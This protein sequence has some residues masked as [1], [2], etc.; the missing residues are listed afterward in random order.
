MTASAAKPRPR[1]RAT[2]TATSPVDSS[3]SGSGGDDL[4]AVPETD[5]ASRRIFR[6]VKLPE[7]PIFALES[8]SDPNDVVEFTGIVALPGL[9]ALRLVTD[10]IDMTTV[11]T[12]FKQ[13][14]GEEGFKKFEEFANVPE[15]GITLDVLVDLS[16]Y[17]M[18][19]YT[20][21][22]TMRSA[23]S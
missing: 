10:G 2:P 16:K 6:G 4:A 23:G 20:G 5:D 3:S 15:H 1:K 8:A 7:R 14:L 13:I 22:P 21:R 12:F 17:L 19:M 11:P 18:E 9:P